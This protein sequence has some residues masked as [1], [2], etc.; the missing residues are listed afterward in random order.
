MLRLCTSDLFCVPKYVWILFQ[1]SLQMSAYTWRVAMRY[2]P[3][4][5][6]PQLERGIAAALDYDGIAEFR[7]QHFFTVSFGRLV[8]VLTSEFLRSS[9]AIWSIFPAAELTVPD[10]FRGS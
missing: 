10:S 9:I 3:S 7:N 1:I 2:S 4:E 6:I 5:L 8:R